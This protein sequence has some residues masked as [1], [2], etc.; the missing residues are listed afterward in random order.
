MHS[1]KSKAREPM[2]PSRMR[3]IH[4]YYQARAFYFSISFLH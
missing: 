4:G 3:D 1:Y 2:Y